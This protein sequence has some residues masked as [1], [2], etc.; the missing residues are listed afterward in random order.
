MRHAIIKQET[1]QKKLSLQ[2]IVACNKYLILVNTHDLVK[3]IKYK[4]TQFTIHILK[5]LYNI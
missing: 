1:R 2:I 3:H 5:H 4:F